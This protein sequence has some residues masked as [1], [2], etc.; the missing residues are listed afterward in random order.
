MTYVYVVALI[1]GFIQIFEIHNSR[2]FPKQ[3]FL[4]SYSRLS[5]RWSIERPYQNWRNK[6][7]FHDALQT[8]KW[9]WI[10]LDH[11]HKNKISLVVVKSTLYCNFKKTILFTIFL[12]LHLYF[13]DFFQ[14]CKICPVK[15]IPRQIS[16]HFQDLKTQYKFCN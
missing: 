13:P 16:R 3:S 10:R 2:L 9:D 6:G 1:G 4:F 11:Y 14:V 8:C 5:N 12:R 15:L 7:F